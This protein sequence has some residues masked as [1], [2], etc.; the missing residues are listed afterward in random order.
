MENTTNTNTAM[1]NTT[2]TNAKNAM[3]AM[4][5]AVKGFFDAID[6]LG[7]AA[8]KVANARMVFIAN[9]TNHFR[10]EK[11]T[12]ILEV[13][14]F[15]ELHKLDPEVELDKPYLRARFAGDHGRRTKTVRE[16]VT[17]TILKIRPGFYIQRVK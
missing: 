14:T 16:M 13:L 3:D 8:E 1:E 11:G 2:N 6:N 7:A 15:E 9:R 12:T 17:G 5:S 4:D 10:G